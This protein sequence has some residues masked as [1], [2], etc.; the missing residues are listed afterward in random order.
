MTYM[1]PESG[2]AQCLPGQVILVIVKHIC[3]RRHGNMAHTTQ[4]VGD[5]TICFIHLTAIQL[6]I[7]WLIDVLQ[8]ISNISN[9]DI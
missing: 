6:L 3:P 5:K 2:A 7:D 4:Y 8:N 1:Q 9:I